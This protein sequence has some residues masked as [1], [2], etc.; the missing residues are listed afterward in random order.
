[1]FSLFPLFTVWFLPLSVSHGPL[2]SWFTFTH[3]HCNFSFLCQY[4]HLMIS[5]QN[6]CSFALA[7]VNRCQHNWAL[8]PQTKPPVKPRAAL[9]APGM[10][11]WLW[12]SWIY[13]PVFVQH[14]RQGHCSFRKAFHIPDW[15]KHQKLF[16]KNMCKWYDGDK[17]SFHSRILK[18][19]FCR[20][21]FVPLESFIAVQLLLKKP[22]PFG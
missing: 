4:L 20:Y 10:L 6:P 2:T 12:G 15:K 16:H 1:M 18:A 11:V 9:G 21:I 19:T 22:K 8:F 5:C 13:L 14:W 3:K 17:L 7:K